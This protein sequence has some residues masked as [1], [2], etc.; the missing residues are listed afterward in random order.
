[1][2]F[3]EETAERYR[4]WIIND[5]HEGANGAICWNTNDSPVPM[6]CWEK[7]GITP[8]PTQAKAI[9]IDVAEFLTE[10]RRNQKPA[11]D[12]ERFEMRAAFGAGATVVDAFSGRVTKL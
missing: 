6:D 5:T 7:A 8:P 4:E 1:M 3:S 12:E 2:G 11:T 10:Y 9:E